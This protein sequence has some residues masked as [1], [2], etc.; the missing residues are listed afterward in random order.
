[1]YP[2]PTTIL[3]R[4]SWR[5]SVLA[6]HA[7][8]WRT[9]APET[10]RGSCHTAQ[11]TVVPP[12]VAPRGVVADPSRM[13]GEVRVGDHQ[14]ARG[15]K[16][17]LRHRAI[18][19]EC[20]PSGSWRKIRAACSSPSTEAARA[21][22]PKTEGHLVVRARPTPSGRARTPG[23][24]LGQPGSAD[25]APTRLS[26]ARGCLARGERHPDARCASI[27]E[28]RGAPCAEPEAV[29]GRR[30]V[31]QPEPA[32]NRAGDAARGKPAAPIQGWMLRPSH[33]VQPSSSQ[34]PDRREPNVTLPT[35]AS[36]R[37]M[38]THPFSTG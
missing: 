13:A 12:I 5:T 23:A 25:S 27:R 31:G 24:R 2:W 16:A 21:H 18:G 30:A 36:A 10:P 4:S 29:V 28:R 38:R 3:S 17:I 15:A 26:P 6:P 32:S 34:P 22:Q 1:M 7:S 9:S 20:Y 19:G 37:T 8:Q 35:T 14:P 11:A 33:K